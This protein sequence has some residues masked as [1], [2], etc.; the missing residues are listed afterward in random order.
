MPP[1]LLSVGIQLL[2]MPSLG[3]HYEPIN[4][5]SVSTKPTLF[6]DSAPEANFHRTILNW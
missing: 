2:S 1:Q 3:R 4:T 5:A 6:R